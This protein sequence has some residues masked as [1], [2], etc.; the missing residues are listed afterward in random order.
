MIA[1]QDYYAIL[2]VPRTATSR[3][4]RRA[5][6]AFARKH[7]PDLNPAD[8]LAAQRSATGL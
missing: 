8:R 3:E 5:Y 1:N 4:I 6:R 7:H 2:S